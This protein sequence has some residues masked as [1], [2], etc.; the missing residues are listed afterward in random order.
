VSRKSRKAAPP[1]EPENPVQPVIAPAEPTEPSDEAPAADEDRLDL[2]AIA[3]RLSARQAERDSAEPA[4]EPAETAGAADQTDPSDPTDPSD[5]PEAADPT[6]PAAPAEEEGPEAVVSEPQLSGAEVFA[7]VEALLFAADRPLTPA[8]IARALPSGVGAR[9]VRAQLAAIGEALADSER[10]FELREIAG[11][12]QLLTREKYAPY[13][14]HLKRSVSIKKL[15]G[16]A[17]ETLAVVAYKQPVGRAEIERIRG[18]NAGEMLRSLLEKRLVRIAGRSAELGNALLYGTT[19]EFLEHFGLKSIGDLPRSAE[20]SRKPVAKPAG[21]APEDGG[22]AVA[23]IGLAA[24]GAA[25]AASD[26]PE[27]TDR[28]D[29]T[30]PSDRP[31]TA[32]QP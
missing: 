31:E 26:Q 18:V 17:L 29:P 32:A 11:G 5:Q 12:W 28:S 13:V 10:G 25:P 15:S 20:L 1:A 2:A 22:A 30:D 24:A 8:Q 9:E 3:A 16:S 19:S 21:A 7:A 6:E 27:P 23:A 14:Q 4:P